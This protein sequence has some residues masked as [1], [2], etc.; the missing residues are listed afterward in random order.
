MCIPRLLYYYS[1]NWQLLLGFDTYVED[2]SYSFMRALPEF[3]H[4]VDP[5]ATHNPCGPLEKKRVTFLLTNYV[6]CRVHVHT[7]TATV[8]THNLSTP[9]FKIDMYVS[10][11]Q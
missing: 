6:V 8:H 4:D 10:R 3:N 9:H 7:C 1:L 11:T 2:D 5:N